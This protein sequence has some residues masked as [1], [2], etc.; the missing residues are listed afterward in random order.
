MANPIDSH[1]REFVFPRAFALTWIAYCGYYLCRKN[2]SVLMPYLKTE[3]GYSSESLAHVLFVYSVA[4]S[5]GQFG[6]GHLADR[7]GARGVV[8]CGALVS[9][10]CSA[11]TGTA[12][13]LLISAAAWIRDIEISHEHD[14]EELSSGHELWTVVLALC[15]AGLVT[16]T[17]LYGVFGAIP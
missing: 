14:S 4:Y 17:G 9:A 6:M 7:V 1:P 2:F 10:G 8:M 15:A 12:F 5:L 3:Q 16:L 13:P 11:L